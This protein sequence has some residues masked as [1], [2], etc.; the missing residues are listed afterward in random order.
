MS[1]NETPDL[2]YLPPPPPRRGALWAAIVLI[3][4]AVLGL[5]AVGYLAWQR[6]LLD[7]LISPQ[8]ESPVKVVA[9][10]DPDAGGEA[11]AG[12]PLDKLDDKVAGLKP[13]RRFADVL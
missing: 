7:N 9:V 11:A 8:P 5:V 2:P 3:A 13:Y 10:Q 12:D 4:V 1:V 6:G